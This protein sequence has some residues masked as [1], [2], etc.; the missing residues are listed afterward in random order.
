MHRALLMLPLALLAACGTPLQQC[1]S[2]AAQELRTID[3]LIRTAQGNIDR[4]YAIAEVE[5]TR[6]VRSRCT[7]RNADGSTFRFPCE[8]TQTVESE[9]PVAIDVAQERIKLRQLQERRAAEQR[10][11]AAAQQQ[12]IATYPEKVGC[13]A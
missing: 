11:F 3:G 12:C 10:R 6:T 2:A 4:G 13:R 5:E 9:V 1:V 8:E 7:G